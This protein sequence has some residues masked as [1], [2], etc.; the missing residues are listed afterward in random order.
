[1]NDIIVYR[2]DLGHLWFREPGSRVVWIVRNGRQCEE[3]FD[4][5]AGA[6]A[7]RE[8]WRSGPDA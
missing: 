5:T 1:M 7:L 4:F 6:Y 8:V 3:P 2:D